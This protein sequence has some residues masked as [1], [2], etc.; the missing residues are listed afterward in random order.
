MARDE[1][2]L[3]RVDVMT[4]R[5]P[6]THVNRAFILVLCVA[7]A[8]T[9]KC[10]FGILIAPEGLPVCCRA[11][12]LPAIGACPGCSSIHLFRMLSSETVQQFPD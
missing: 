7:H 10:T 12:T 4:M 2:I 6:R 9:M 8:P 3:S 11:E 5:T 1:K